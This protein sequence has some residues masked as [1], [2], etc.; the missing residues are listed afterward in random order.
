M[1]SEKN[2]E[3]MVFSEKDNF[4]WVIVIVARTLDLLPPVPIWDPDPEVDEVTYDEVDEVTYDEVQTLQH[5]SFDENLFSFPP[6]PP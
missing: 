3:N 4:D 5:S 6:H 2:P 1:F